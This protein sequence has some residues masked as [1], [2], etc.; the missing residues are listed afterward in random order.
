MRLVPG[1]GTEDLMIAL[2]IHVADNG[3]PVWVHTD[4][5]SQLVKAGKAVNTD[6]PD[7]DFAQLAS[8][9]KG[10]VRWSTC[11]AAAQHRN[12]ALESAVK[13]LKRTL[14]L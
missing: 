3:L 14:N 5:G 11:P 10:A 12:G 2:N 13:K 8:L 7:W 6:C 4:R 1:Y 9:G